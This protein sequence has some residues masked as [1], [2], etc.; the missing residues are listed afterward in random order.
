MDKHVFVKIQKRYYKPKV[1]LCV[2]TKLS[3]SNICGPPRGSWRHDRS[4]RYFLLG[5]GSVDVFDT[6]ADYTVEQNSGQNL[7]RPGNGY[8][9]C[10]SVGRAAVVPNFVGDVNQLPCSTRK[11]KTPLFLLFN[12]T[13]VHPLRK[14]LALTVWPPSGNECKQQDF[15]KRFAICFW[16]KSIL[17]NAAS[18]KNKRYMGPRR[19][20]RAGWSVGAKRNVIFQYIERDLA[21]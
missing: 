13:A 9:D 3:T 2:Q 4:R 7:S 1:N 17:E 12:K 6:Y 11:E 14:T 5:L 19:M 10:S 21:E 16:P 20:I 8:G 18:W 15:Q